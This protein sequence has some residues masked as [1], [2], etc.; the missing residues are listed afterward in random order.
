[1]AIKPGS[2]FEET[3]NED[4]EEMAEGEDYG[5]M[6][7]EEGEGDALAAALEQAGFTV[8]PAKLEQVRSI[9]EGGPA[10]EPKPFGG[11]ETPEEEE[12]EAGSVPEEMNPYA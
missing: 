4:T 12:S 8:D 2:A 1:M 5:S 11:T 10:G 9:L 6:F 3:D 7:G